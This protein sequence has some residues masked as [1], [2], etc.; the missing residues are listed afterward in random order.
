ME[1]ITT[2]QDE[3]IMY[4]APLTIKKNC[5]YLVNLFHRIVTNYDSNEFN[6]VTLLADI[7]LARENCNEIMAAAQLMD[8]SLEKLHH[9]L[10]ENV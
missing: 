1:E 8:A 6:A 9:E 10:T 2:I 5:G 7:Q 3:C 4:G